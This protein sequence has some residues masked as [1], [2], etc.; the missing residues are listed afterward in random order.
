[1]KWGMKVR[2]MYPARTKMLSGGDSAG[3][4]SSNLLLYYVIYGEMTL[5]GRLQLTLLFHRINNGLTNRV[6]REL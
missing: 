2:E 6:F 4:S 3:I 1:M 5:T